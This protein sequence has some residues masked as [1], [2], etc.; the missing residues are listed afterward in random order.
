M[1]SSFLAAW[2]SL[3][4]C[5]DAALAEAMRTE[6]SGYQ[7]VIQ[8]AESMHELLF[9]EPVAELTI[10]LSFLFLFDCLGASIF[11]DAVEHVTGGFSQT[12]LHF[13]RLVHHQVTVVFRCER[14]P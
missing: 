8:L 3:T 7:S 10:N 12:R 5:N 2:A 9:I 11:Q 4:R 6:R 14:L 1:R 13:E